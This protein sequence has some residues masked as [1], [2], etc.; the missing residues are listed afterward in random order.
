MALNGPLLPEGR[1]SSEDRSIAAGQH[2]D[3]PPA[4]RQDGADHFRDSVDETDRHI[5]RKTCWQHFKKCCCP[6][7]QDTRSQ[8]Q[9][10]ADKKA[11]CRIM[12]CVFLFVAGLCV[13]TYEYEE[14]NGHDDDDGNHNNTASIN[15]TRLLFDG[16]QLNLTQS[17][18]GLTYS[19]VAG[20]AAMLVGVVGIVMIGLST[21]NES[22]GSTSS[23]SRTPESD[24]EASL[25]P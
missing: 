14:H 12:L 3:H 7:G 5:R 24:P 11:Q 1:S 4:L 9:Q 15:A 6:Q 20:F 16:G 19:Q 2:P 22:N 18:R 17:T 23:D 25:K 13:A 10:A 21:Y 8:E